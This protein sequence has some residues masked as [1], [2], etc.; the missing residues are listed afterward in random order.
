[1]FLAV[2]C[3]KH[4]LAHRKFSASRTKNNSRPFGKRRSRRCI[5]RGLQLRIVIAMLL[6]KDRSLRQPIPSARIDM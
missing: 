5:S 6:A 3:T 4:N 2:S 1:M